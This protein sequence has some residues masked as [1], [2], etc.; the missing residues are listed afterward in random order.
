[1]R[2]IRFGHQQPA[3]LPT[4]SGTVSQFDSFTGKKGGRG[5]L[6][7]VFSVRIVLPVVVGRQIPGETREKFSQQDGRGE[8]AERGAKTSVM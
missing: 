6:F 1:M 2:K 8:V 3:T 4:T 5:T 7:G